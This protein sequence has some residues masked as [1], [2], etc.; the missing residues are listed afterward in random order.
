MLH[1]CLSVMSPNKTDERIKMPFGCMTRVGQRNYV[2]DRGPDSQAK[3]AI[4]WGCLAH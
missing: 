1:V 3:G 2:L 4:L